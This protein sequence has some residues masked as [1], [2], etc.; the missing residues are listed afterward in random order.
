MSPHDCIVIVHDENA[1]NGADCK[2]CLGGVS[3]N[4]AAGLWRINTADNLK[5]RRADLQLIRATAGNTKATNE[6]SLSFHRSPGEEGQTTGMCG[7]TAL[8]L[9]NGRFL[10]AGEAK[11]RSMF[12]GFLFQFLIERLV[13]QNVP[14]QTVPAS[15]ELLG[16]LLGD[17]SAIGRSD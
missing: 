15:Y 17:V 2:R 14:Y 6:S 4:V 5:G 13:L 10:I 11:S 9:S 12:K 16:L 3:K 7:R 1:Q 8:L